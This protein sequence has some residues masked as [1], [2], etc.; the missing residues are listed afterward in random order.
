MVSSPVGHQFEALIMLMVCTARHIICV[1]CESSRGEHF[2]EEAC[3]DLTAD[4]LVQASSLK[5]YGNV[6]NKQMVDDLCPP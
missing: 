4:V 3:R 2:P 1:M 6:S 5:V